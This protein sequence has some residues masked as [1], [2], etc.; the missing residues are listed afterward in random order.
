MVERSFQ[1]YTP[2][3]EYESLLKDLYYEKHLLFGRDKLYRYIQDNLEPKIPRRYIG[4]WLSKQTTQQVFRHKHKPTSIRPIHSNAAN[5][6][7]QIDLIDF[8]QIPNNGYKYILTG[9]DVYS[10]YIVL[11]EPLR[12]KTVNNVKQALEKV[13]EK[14]GKPK[15][16]QS[17]NGKEFRI[18]LWLRSLG[19][20]HFLSSIYTPQQNGIIE[21]SNGTVKTILK[22][23]LF[24]NGNN[25]W[26]RYTESIQNT[27]NNTYQRIIKNTPKNI[28]ST[29]AEPAARV[30]N[31]PQSLTSYKVGDKVRLVLLNKK[32]KL[33]PS[34]SLNTFEIKR[35]IKKN[36]QIGSSERY[37]LIDS[38]DKVIKGYFNSSKLILVTGA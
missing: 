19:I 36:E 35:V 9:I 29:P 16:I 7:W 6:I 28:Y 24:L 21:R 11:F 33:D 37:Q 23:V 5:N 27:Y 30:V 38:D 18:A 22:K 2:I 25:V 4:Y 34:Y 1:E 13:F 14:Y 32:S 10:R 12:A 3:A 8:T 17:D 31:N 26:L 20:K 15:L